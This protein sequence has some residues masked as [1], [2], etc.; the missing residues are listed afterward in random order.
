MKK[1]RKGYIP[2]QA[3]EIVPHIRGFMP[4][5]FIDCGAAD[6]REA[7]VLKM[8]FPKI[9]VLGI[10][11]ASSL[12]DYS[13]YPG[14]MISAAAWDSDGVAICSGMEKERARTSSLVRG[15]AG[16]QKEVKT[17]KLDTLHSTY[18][19]K[20]AILW[21][22][23]EGAEM[24]VLRGAAGLF[25]DRIIQAV[26]IEVYDGEGEAEIHNWLSKLDFKRVLSYCH[27]GSHHDNFYVHRSLQ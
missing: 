17:V 6:G 24:N 18:K 16:E 13:D 25:S 26:N 12:F 2:R 5:W 15:M 14:D 23:V 20:N 3:E 7:H 11:V 9:K 19:F 1:E 27:N 4:E 22:D 21:V 10:E 8:R